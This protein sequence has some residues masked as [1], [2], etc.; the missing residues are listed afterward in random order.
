MLLSSGDV[1]SW[2]D[3]DLRRL[4]QC[5]SSGVVDPENYPALSPLRCLSRIEI[6]RISACGNVAA[7]V[8][9]AGQLF[10][11]S[12]HCGFIYFSLF[13]ALTLLVGRQEG[14]PACRN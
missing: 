10:T 1:Y 4:L 6:V 13:S 11:W 7:A 2:T 3:D 9:R 12:D 5:G 8:S 14:H